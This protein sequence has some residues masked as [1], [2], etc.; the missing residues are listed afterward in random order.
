MKFLEVEYYISENWGGKYQ[1]THLEL[2]RTAINIEHIVSVEDVPVV[3]NWEKRCDYTMI[4]LVGGLSYLVNIP[5]FAVME[6]IKELVRC[7]N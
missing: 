2:H 3:G 6:L 5:Y 7:S 1:I 4:H